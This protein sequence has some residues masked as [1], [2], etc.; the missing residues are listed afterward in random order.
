[1]FFSFQMTKWFGSR[2]SKLLDVG[3]RSV[4]KS[5]RCL[6][7]EPEPGPEIWVPDQLAQPI[8]IRKLHLLR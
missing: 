3:A 4:A 8:T 7:L 6:E 1:M 5:F 2:S